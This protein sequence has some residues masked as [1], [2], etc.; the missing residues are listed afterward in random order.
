[1]FPLLLHYFGGVHLFILP[2]IRWYEQ[3][4]FP[5]SKMFSVSSGPPYALA[6]VLFILCQS[7]L[8]FPLV[9]PIWLSALLIP[10]PKDCFH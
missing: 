10:P 2:F 1:M 7:V 5:N 8:E 6:T 3:V 4:V 9:S